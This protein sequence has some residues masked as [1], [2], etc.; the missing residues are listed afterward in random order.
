MNALMWTIMKHKLSMSESAITQSPYLLR[1]GSMMSISMTVDS[2]LTPVD[3][4]TLW[5]CLN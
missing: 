2:T 4:L 3:R 1:D 5:S